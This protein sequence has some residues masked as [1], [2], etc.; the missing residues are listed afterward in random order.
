M[1]ISIALSLALMA[2]LS[3]PRAVASSFS[4]L[5]ESGN[6]QSR[7]LRNSPFK[8]DPDLIFKAQKS[9]WELSQI[10]GDTILE[11]DFY[12]L[13]RTRLD[14]L[15]ELSHNL[16]VIG[17]RVTYSQKAWMTAHCSYDPED[18]ATLANC[19]PGRIYE[20]GFLSIN[21]K[22]SFRDENAMAEFI[23]N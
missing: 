15:E 12:A 2:F 14:T 23:E 20:S 1:K 9:S 4:D 5:I 22:E 13:N 7:I 3:G 18:I 17:Y 16:K 6:Y 21:F 11:G 10:W 19:V 8:I